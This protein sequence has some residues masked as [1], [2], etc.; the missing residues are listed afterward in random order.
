[1]TQDPAERVGVGA[2][3]GLEGALG[4]AA[5]RAGRPGVLFDEPTRAETRREGKR[6]GEGEQHRG[7]EGDGELAEEFFHEATHKQNRD[8]D[9]DEGE[10]HRQQREPDLGRAAHRR[11]ERGEPALD[12]AGDVFEHDDGVVH[13][14]TGGDDQ[15][16]QREI[17]ERETVEIHDRERADEGHGDRETRDEGGAGAAEKKKHHEHHEP[18]GNHQRMLGFA[19]RSADA[20]RAVHDDGEIGVGGQEGAKG[21]KLG[22]DRVD[23]CDDVGPGLAADHQDDGGAVIVKAAA[24]AVLDRVGDLGHIAEADRRAVAV[25]DDKRQILFGATQLVA[26]LDLPLPVGAFDGAAWPDGVGGR[27]RAAHLVKGDAVVGEGVGVQLHAHG[28]QRTAADGDLA[29]AVD[30]GNFLRE[31]RGSGV[32]E[33]AGREIRR[34][35]RQGHDGGLRRIG[36][37]VGGIAG[38]AGGKLA[39]GGIDRGLDIAGGGVDVAVET[40]FKRDAGGPL[41]A[42]RGD[43]RD[44]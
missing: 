18:G 4:R 21:R 44:A 11:A 7:G 35:E 20:G 33:G 10:V 12:V 40:K 3:D 37:T 13:H 19:Q 38:H 43:R 26:D 27:N 32:V 9:R 5:Q 42:V 17:V 8:E 28:R 31:N 1:M 6:D 14:E 23:R 2:A 24:V 25:A 30:L 41:A 29:D 36:F 22:G 16:H 39:A 34:A 15:R